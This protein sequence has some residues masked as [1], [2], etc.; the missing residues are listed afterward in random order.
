MK[1]K[2]NDKEGT[3]RVVRSYLE[4]RFE[5]FE[6]EEEWRPNFNEHRFRIKGPD[7]EVYGVHV[8]EDFLLSHA[9]PPSIIESLLDTWNPESTAGTPLTTQGTE[10]LWMV[11]G[12]S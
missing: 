9:R 5:G 7:N 11:D 12:V 2:H 10:P 4:K 6:I 3:V 8:T 1:H